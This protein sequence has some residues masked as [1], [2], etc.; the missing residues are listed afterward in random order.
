MSVPHHVGRF[1]IANLTKLYQKGIAGDYD[2]ESE[3]KFKAGMYEVC[4]M[5]IQ[6]YEN[7]ERRI[8]DYINSNR[9]T[10]KQALDVMCSYAIAEEGTNTLYVGLVQ[11]LALRDPH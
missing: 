4:A 6:V 9:L 11:L 3:D 5:Y 10:P 8:L 2:D 1:M 7:I